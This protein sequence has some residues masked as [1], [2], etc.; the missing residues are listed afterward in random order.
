MEKIIRKGWVYIIGVMLVLVYAWGVKNMYFHQDDLDWFILANK[1]F[2]QVLQAPIADHVNYLWRLLLSLEWN[3]F[4]LHFAPYLVVSLLLHTAVIWL[5]Y[6]IAFETT[7]RR[8]LSGIVAI[9]FAI[10][11][12][13]TEII[14]W[15]SGQTIS[16]TVF[17]VLLAMYAMLRKRGQM[18]TMLMSGITSALSLGLPIASLLVYGYDYDRRKLNRIGIVAIATLLIVIC[19]YYFMGGDGTTIEYSLNWILK[20][21]EVVFLMMIN[22]VVGRTLIPFDKYE[23]WRIGIV[24]TGAILLGLKYRSKFIEIWRDNWSRFLIFQLF[25]Y[26]LIVAIGRAQ[27]GVGIMRAERYAYLGLA[28]TLLIIA[29][30]LRNTKINKLIWILAVLMIIQIVGFYRRAGD[31]IERPVKLK[32]LIIEIKRGDKHPDNDEYLPYFV[33]NDERLKYGDLYNLMK[34]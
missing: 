20:V 18:V 12:N 24:I 9:I 28:L 30:T 34:R 27:Y 4:Q 16:I 29:R 33:L 17:F 7:K 3:I 6:K 11:T 23:I 19:A 5:L 31:Y 32:Q 14:L 8:D 10:N 22:T 21:G 2:L 15:I 25:F 26:N 1:P 13:W